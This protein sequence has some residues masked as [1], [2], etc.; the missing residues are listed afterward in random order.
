MD[1]CWV[2]ETIGRPTYVEFLGIVVKDKIMGG[3]LELLSIET[4]AL[5]YI[6]GVD[7]LKLLVVKEDIVN[8]KE[9]AGGTLVPLYAT[10][11]ITDLTWAATVILLVGLNVKLETQLWVKTKKNYVGLASYK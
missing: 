8:F 7:N 10:V 9:Q 6:T 1:P 11:K 5:R 4:L 2:L 3:V